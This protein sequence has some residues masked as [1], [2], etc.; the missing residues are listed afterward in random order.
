MDSALCAVG[1]YRSNEEKH[2]TEQRFFLTSAYI[3]EAL[4]DTVKAYD[5]LW[6][7]IQLDTEERQEI[8]NDE[9]K[10]EDDRIN[11]EL[12]RAR[13]AYS[14][15]IA[16]LGA[17]LVSILSFHFVK[18]AKMERTALIHS[19]LELEVSQKELE[20]DNAALQAKYE[21]TLADFIKNSQNSEMLR[22]QIEQ[23]ISMFHKLIASYIS[24]DGLSKPLETELNTLVAD[25]ESLLCSLRNYTTAM[26][27]RMTSFLKEKQLTERE[28]DICNLYLL[29][30]RGKEIGSYL[31]ISR[32]YSISSD[33]RKK[34]GLTEHDTNIG[35][36]LRQLRD[37]LS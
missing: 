23:R 31:N 33:I 28:I 29:G 2:M 15:T 11:Y 20:T 26:Y 7:Y 1:R 35:P 18:K 17:I 24:H 32:H 12:K 14:L 6:E 30:L 36:H 21:K 3:Y 25:K 22:N 4:G 27:P 9:T 8:Y 19:K 34:V 5:N 10:Y 16:I 37:S 13:L